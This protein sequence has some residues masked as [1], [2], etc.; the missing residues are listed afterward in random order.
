MHMESKESARD[1]KK[2]RDTSE[3]KI[4]ISSEPTVLYR[5]DNGAPYAKKFYT[6]RSS[7][8]WISIDVYIQIF[9]D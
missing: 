4:H 9:N 2:L 1:E 8:D 6:S 3:C 7:A 5:G